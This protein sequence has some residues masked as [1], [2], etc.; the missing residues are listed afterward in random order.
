MHRFSSFIKYVIAIVFFL[1]QFILVLAQS[2]HELDSLFNIARKHAFNQEFEVARTNCNEILALDSTYLDAKVLM[3]NTYAWDQNYSKGME[4]LEEVIREKYG[5]RDALISLVDICLWK[6]DTLKASQYIEVGLSFHPGDTAFISRKKR[7]ESRPFASSTRNQREIQE[8]KIP[9]MNLDSLFNE[10][11]NLAYIDELDRARYLCY[12]IIHRDS[13]YYDAALLIGRIYGWQRD[14]DSA[15]FWINKVLAVNDHYREAWLAKT[16]VSLWS[17][18]YREVISF[19][20]SAINTFTQPD[21][22]I[23]RKNIAIE[24][25]SRLAQPNDSLLP[26]IGFPAEEG[27]FNQDQKKKIIFVDYLFDHFQKPYIRRWHVLS[28]GYGQQSTTGFYSAQIN[29]GDLV[30]NG[31]KFVSNLNYQF[32]L[33]AYPRLSSKSY[34]FLSYGVSPGPLFPG[35]YAGMEYFRNLGGGFEASLGIRYMYWNRHLFFFTGSVSKYFGNYWIAF[36]PY[37]SQKADIFTNSYALMFRRFFANPADYLFL[38]LLTGHSPDQPYYLIESS[39]SFS[40]HRGNIGLV[41]SFSDSY[42]GRISVGYQYEEYLRNKW[43]N[44]FD[45]SFGVMYYFK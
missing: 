24:R 4:M 19:C 26:G 43:R 38:N 13:S 34:A 5:H 11:K 10:A 29:I 31:E 2:A 36:R 7:T 42:A 25:L 23:E 21:D 15:M 9:E 32:L 3:A 6:N 35:H 12:D 33:T 44:R 14:F 28:T 18:N 39:G 1:S 20:D 40:S 27:R 22:F 17:A 8:S 16:D 30:T 45:F 37:I 41:K